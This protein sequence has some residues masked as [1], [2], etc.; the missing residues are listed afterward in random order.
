[1]VPTITLAQSPPDIEIKSNMKKGDYV[2]TNLW[3]QTTNITFSQ[4]NNICPQNDCEYEFQ[5]GTFNDYGGTRYITGTL[6]IE[7]KSKSSGN[8]TSFNYFEVSGTFEL[9]NSNESPTEKIFYYGG[10]LKIEKKADVLAN[11]EYLS[12]ITLSEP[13]NTFVLEG[14]SK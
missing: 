12:N 11:F 7:D 6:K 14:T 3:F 5:D 9:Q 10:D 4:G 2:D 8:F 1:M 13:S